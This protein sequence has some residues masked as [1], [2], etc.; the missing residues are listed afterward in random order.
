MGLGVAAYALTYWGILATTVSPLGPHVNAA[1][2]IGF[3][4]LEGVTWPAF[5]G[6]SL[7]IA[8]LVGR[9]LGAKRPDLAWVSIR[10]KVSS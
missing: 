2:G 6:F 3:S 5:H 10:K 8:S 9:S 7:A 1:L 4:A